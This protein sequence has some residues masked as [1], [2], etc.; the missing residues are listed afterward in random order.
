MTSS[1]PPWAV[2]GSRSGR[3]TMAAIL[4]LIGDPVEYRAILMVGASNLVRYSLYREE[5]N[6]RFATLLDANQADI[7]TPVISSADNWILLAVTKATGSV[8]TKLHHYKYDTAT[9]THTNRPIPNMGSEAAGWLLGDEIDMTQGP[10][11][12]PSAIDAIKA[13]HYSVS[14]LFYQCAGFNLH[15]Y[16]LAHRP[17]GNR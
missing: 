1:I 14:G 17:V 6:D 3:G 10:D 7:S 8:A 2:R 16:V 5:A 4:K 12:C 15:R 9:W 13:P 11:A